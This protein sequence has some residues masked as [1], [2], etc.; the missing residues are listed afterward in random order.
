MTEIKELLDLIFEGEEI[1]GYTDVFMEDEDVHEKE[2]AIRYTAFSELLGDM[3]A[4]SYYEETG[5]LRFAIFDEESRQFTGERHV[6]G[7]DDL[8]TMQAEEVFEKFETSFYEYL[9]SLHDDEQPVQINEDFKE[10]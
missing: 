1:E 2:K 10:Q 6:C 5:V 7:L 4:A 8:K 3:V 9:D